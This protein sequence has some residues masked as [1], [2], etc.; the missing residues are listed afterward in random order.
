[1]RARVNTSAVDILSSMEVRWFVDD[2]SSEATAARAWF[3]GVKAEGKRE[4]HYLLTGRDDFA[5]KARVQEGVPSK[6]ETKYLL[7]SLGPAL[8]H[9]RFVGNVESWRKLS[10]E[11]SD[12]AL[13]QRGEW[14]RVT[15]QRRMRRFGCEGKT[16]H[17]LDGASRPSAGCNV[18]L[19]ELE[20]E[21]AGARR[22]ALTIGFEAFGPTERL[23]DVL[24]R[25][26]EAALESARGLRLGFE[27][28]ESYPRWLAHLQ[29]IRSRA[30]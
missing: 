14:A 28:S 20:L 12:P 24:L 25:V 18:E 23:L 2:A 5:F 22:K 4:D 27:R 9:E 29:S 1:M 11:A 26:S 30:S 15:K 6:L 7:G 8:L 19:T 17:A 13:E 10:V 16:V 21:L 3:D